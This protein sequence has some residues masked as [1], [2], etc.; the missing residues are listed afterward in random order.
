MCDSLLVIHRPPLRVTVSVLILAVLC[1]VPSVQGETLGSWSSSTPYPIAIYFSHC[2]TYSG[3]I[4]CVGGETESEATPAVYSAPVSSGSVGAWSNAYTH[5]YPSPE[6]QALSCAAY[7]GYIYCVGGPYS[8]NV[9]YASIGGGS[10]GTW[11]ETTSYPYD[12]SDSSCVASSGYLYC[13]GG[14]SDMGPIDDVFYAQVSS[15]GVGTWMKTSTY[16]NDDGVMGTSCVIYSGYIYCVGGSTPTES[17][18]GTNV[19]YYAA[20]SSSGVGT[21]TLSANSYPISTLL[22]PCVVLSGY[23]YCVGGTPF[24]L[25]SYT[26][27]VYYAQLGSGVGAWT[28]TTPYPTDISVESCVSYS[29]YIYC[30]GGLTSNAPT[31]ETDAV[32]SITVTQPFAYSLSNSGGITATPG[33]S[34]SNTITATL[35]TGTSQSVTLSCTGGL[36]AGASCSFNPASGSP[37]FSSTLTISTSTTTPTGSYTI[38]VNGYPAPTA[39]TS[40]SLTVNPSGPVT[41]T[42]SYL[43]V[44]GGTP[45]APVFKYVLNGVSKSLTLKKKLQK[46]SA[47]AGS[48]W[49]VTPNPLAGSSPSQQWYSTQTLTGT[50]SATA[51]V[52][53]FQHQYYLTMVANGP[54]SVSPISGWHNAGATVTVTATPNPGHS[55]KSWTGTGKGH[56]K[57]T[58]NPGTITM[59]GAITEIANF[60]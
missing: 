20:V 44:G 21:W 38:T 55:F 57:G 32:Y 35:Q 34:G 30:V 41:M 29:G 13:V 36:P 5:P 25:S 26:N 1:L 6:P 45:T 56:C 2:V 53:T 4:Y 15:S 33:S 49:S 18:S 19:V 7:S 43:V 24:T 54:G 27:A 31:S 46:V 51:I 42:V 37:T 28:S 52:F 12:I 14:L 9:Y 39:P 23:M 10:V 11:T 47:D 40:F 17:T 8:G 3:Y 60:T 48:P 59:N 50:A 22:L 58:Y 16:P